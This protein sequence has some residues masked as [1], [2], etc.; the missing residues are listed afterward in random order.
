M[1][2][3]T[4]ISVYLIFILLLYLFMQLLCLYKASYQYQSTMENRIGKLISQ[5]VNE[6]YKEVADN[7][8]ILINL[9]FSVFMQ[10]ISKQSLFLS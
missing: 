4:H 1:H 3:T 9:F 5:A 2:M 10:L 6:Q 7:S 8:I